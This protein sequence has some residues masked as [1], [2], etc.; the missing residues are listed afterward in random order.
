MRW[1]LRNWYNLGPAVTIVALGLGVFLDLSLLQR[2]LLLSFALLPLHEFEEYGWPGG[3]P[4]FMNTVI[5]RSPQPDRYP[6]NRLNSV[7]V[8]VIAAYPFYIVPIF[9]PHVIWLGLAPMLF[10]FGEL[11]IHLGGGVIVSRAAY[12]PGFATIWPWAAV[13]IWY[14]VEIS[15]HAQITGWDWLIAVVYMVVW[16]LVSLPLLTFRILARRNSSHPFDDVELG[17]INKYIRL[18]HRAIHPHEA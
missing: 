8:N 3:F 16:T 2:I 18:V 13:S 17:R 7:V 9:L 1:Y 11:L 4:A 5:M 6:L 15:S 10:N 12:S 14:I